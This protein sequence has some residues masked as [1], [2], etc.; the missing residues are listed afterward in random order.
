MLKKQLIFLSFFVFSICWITALKGQNIIT[1]FTIKWNVPVEVNISEGEFFKYLNFDDARYYENDEFTPYFSKVI[2]IEGNPSSLSAQLQSPKFIAMESNELQWFN[3]LHLLR[4]SI[5]VRADIGLSRGES[6]AIVTLLPFRINPENGQI[7]KLLSGEIYLN[8]SQSFEKEVLSSNFTNNSVLSSGN[9][10][11]IKIDRTGIFK[12]TYDQ[13]AGMGMNVNSLKSANIRVFGNGGGTLPESNSAPRFDDL[14]ETAIEVFDGGD[15]IFNQGDYFVFYGIGPDVWNFVPILFRFAHKK[16]LYDDWAYYFITVD[17]GTGKRVAAQPPSTLTANYISTS[18]SDYT[19]HE[20][21]EVNLIKSGREWYGETFDLINT[22]D[23]NFS[24]PNL[25]KDVQQH[26]KIRTYAKSILTSS[27]V[28][29]INDNDQ[30]VISIGG[31]PDNPEGLYAK[32]GVGEL[33]FYVTNDKINVGLKYNKP[34]TNAVGWLDY[35]ELNVTRENIFTGGQMAFR[36]V[37]SK[38]YEKVTEFQLRNVNSGVTIWEVTDRH[39]VTSI[40]AALSGNMMSFTLPTEESVREFIAFDGTEY[41]DVQPV[42]PVANQNLHA[43]SN[44]DYVIVTHP[45]FLP[46]ALRLAGF[47]TSY[48]DLNTYVVTP[49]LIYNE[50]SS[51]SMDPTAIRDMMRMLYERG[52]TGKKPRYL[53]LFGDA[54]YDPKERLSNNTNFIH[55]FQSVNS[56]HYVY[57]YATDDYFGFLD[58]NEGTGDNQMLDVGIGR[59]VVRT[60]QEAKMAVDKTIHYA[61]F[62]EN[63]GPWRNVVTFV[64]DDE[65]QNIHLKQAEQLAVYVDTT[66]KNYNVDKIYIDAYFQEST[67]GGARYPSVNKAINTR[68]EK[69]TLIINYTGHGGELG[70]AHERI[71]ENADINSWKNYNKL[72]V[73]ITATCEFARYDDPGRISAGEYVFLNPSGGGIALFTTSRLTYGSHNLSLIAGIYKYAFEQNVQE[74]YSMGDLLRIAKLESP[75]YLNDRKYILLGDPALKIAHPYYNIETTHINQRPINE[76]NEPDTLKALSTVTVSGRITDEFNNAVS[77]FNGVLNITVF[78]KETEVTTLGQDPGSY[79]KSFMLRKNTLFNGRTEVINGTFTFSFIVPKDIAYQYGFGKISYY[80]DDGDNDASG[81]YDNIVVGGYDTTAKMDNKGPEIKLYMNDTTFVNGGITNENPILL[82]LVFDESGINTVGNSIGHDI[83]AILDGNSDNPFLLNDFYQA[84][85]RGF[86]SGRVRYPF[87]NLTPG[88]HEIK[89]KIWD[90]FNNSS[91]SFIEFEVISQDN[92]VIEGVRNY[93]NPVTDYTYFVFNHNKADSELEITLDIFDLSGRNVVTLKQF[94]TS[95]S[96]TINPIY[97][98][99]TNG[100]GMFLRKGIYIYRIIAK[101]NA[102]KIASGSNKL[103]ILK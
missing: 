69:G 71:L 56:D 53:L 59:F 30:L 66:Y 9:W 73:F 26:I 21:D 54:S 39:N 35:I 60:L 49:D 95:T 43:I 78:D 89:F 77:D 88:K 75:D 76:N 52:K 72:A 57:S 31:T 99:G 87:Y 24:F 50:F 103:V 68:I 80:A 61:T 84:D 34:A 6:F 2:K 38:D 67:T 25:K 32:E 55:T 16:N 13:L 18:I 23:Y 93:P 64:A 40:Q 58:P 92:M 15:G 47:H 96:F 12:V 4:E 42:G 48:S 7:E 63:Y 3:S 14:Q 83:T 20:L 44:I 90:V 97:W 8:Y 79:P 101:D 62:S 94:D 22:Y 85:L 46:E 51:G 1:P 74:F 81:F 102:G 82:A 45:D 86:Q 27:F 41:Y 28:A 17:K 70:W 19:F 5:D 10:F 36:D 91:E 98:D 65:N 29:N 100:N 33:K 37:W 11:K